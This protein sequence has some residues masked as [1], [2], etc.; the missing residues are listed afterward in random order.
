MA[1]LVELSDS[2]GAIDLEI[3]LLTVRRKEIAWKIA[4]AEER[5]VMR[6]KANVVGSIIRDISKVEDPVVSLKFT[7]AHLQPFK[8]TLPH[9]HF[10]NMHAV[11][12]EILPSAWTRAKS[13]E[14][15]T[16]LNSTLEC[17]IEAFDAEMFL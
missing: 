7:I 13:V 2:L 6:A 10:G 8:L 17:D 3:D 5:T 9:K 4:D 16:S 14:F 1:N 15:F 12:P 11:W